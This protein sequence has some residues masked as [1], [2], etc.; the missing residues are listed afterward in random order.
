[1][2][3]TPRKSLSAAALSGRT[4]DAN[5]PD[6]QAAR[7]EK[8][9]AALRAMAAMGMA[10]AED[11]SRRALAATDPA[12]IAD[13][14]GQFEQL[15]VSIC[16]TISMEA[17]LE[18]AERARQARLKAAAP[19]SDQVQA[20]LAAR[21]IAAALRQL[22]RER[23]PTDQNPRGEDPAPWVTKPT[24]SGTGSA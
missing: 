9:L 13:L 3:N 24:T 1:M 4:C 14:A 10:L 18:Q 2:S 16:E 19:V 11:V 6:N 20:A 12:E 7:A 5:Q 17:E 15:A 23:R 21:E 22:R 8:Q